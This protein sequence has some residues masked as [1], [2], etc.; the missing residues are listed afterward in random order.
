MEQL[1]EN[2]IFESVNGLLRINPEEINNDF[3]IFR[4]FSY[5]ENFELNKGIHLKILFGFS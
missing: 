2:R 5:I 4:P 3:D 1:G